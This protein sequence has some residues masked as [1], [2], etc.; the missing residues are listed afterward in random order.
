MDAETPADQG[1]AAATAQRAVGVGSSPTGG[2]SGGSGRS[3]MDVEGGDA[4]EAAAG[5]DGDGDGGDD[6]ARVR[7]EGSRGKAAMDVDEREQQE[8]ESSRHVSFLFE[9]LEVS[10]AARESPPFGGCLC[11]RVA[12]VL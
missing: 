6:G 3:A 11:V 7:R 9:A 8:A 2:T 10:C 1:G 5:G 4:A 12:L